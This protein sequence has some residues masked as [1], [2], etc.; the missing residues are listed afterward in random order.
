MW[1]CG[2]GHPHGR[3]VQERG[4]LESTREGDRRGEGLAAAIAG[5]QSEDEEL[6]STRGKSHTTGTAA[7]SAIGRGRWGP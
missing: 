5:R 6:R 2:C 1:G 7:P 4:A 3:S